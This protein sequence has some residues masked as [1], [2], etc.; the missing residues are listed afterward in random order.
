[1]T[2]EAD[3][4]PTEVAENPRLTKPRLS[5]EISRHPKAATRPST[6]LYANQPHGYYSRKPGSPGSREP[7]GPQI[8][9]T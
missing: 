3:I 1:M 6:G 8:R 2:N 4:T 9:Q 5:A 7:A